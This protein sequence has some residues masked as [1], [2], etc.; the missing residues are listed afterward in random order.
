M[1]NLAAFLS[2]GL[3][4]ARAT[5]AGQDVPRFVAVSRPTVAQFAADCQRPIDKPDQD[6]R[7]AGCL[8]YINGALYQIGMAKGSADC[9]TALNRVGPGP[10][11]E[12]IFS[13]VPEMGQRPVG[14]VLHLIVVNVSAKACR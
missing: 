9:W 11:S 13:T 14:D 6:I 2:I 4:F 12:V 8:S 10:L 1:N 5:A 3:C 7:I